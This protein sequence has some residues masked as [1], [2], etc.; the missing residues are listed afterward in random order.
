MITIYTIHN[1]LFQSLLK[2]IIDA[3]LAEPEWVDIPAKKREAANNIIA[4]TMMQGY[5]KQI[6]EAYM[7]AYSKNIRYNITQDISLK[8]QPEQALGLYT[9]ISFL[10]L[11]ADDVHY[12]L[13]KLLHEQLSKLISPIVMIAYPQI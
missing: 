12:D 6:F 9:A 1:F 2:M 10:N 8:M 7:K 11:K 13:C 3:R 5:V 4:V